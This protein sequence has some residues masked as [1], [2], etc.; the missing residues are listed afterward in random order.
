MLGERC[1]C[2]GIDLVLWREEKTQ[3]QPDIRQLSFFYLCSPVFSCHPAV[4]AASCQ[5]AFSVT[6][7]ITTKHK[8]VEQMYKLIRSSDWNAASEQQLSSSRQLCNYTVCLFDCFSVIIAAG[9]KMMLDCLRTNWLNNTTHAW[10]D[11]WIPFF[12]F[13]GKDFP[14]EEGSR[15]LWR[16]SWTGEAFIIDLSLGP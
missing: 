15:R 9:M 13:Q 2:W 12:V 6:A 7:H 3:F 14:W 16:Q 11:S 10:N 5:I 1:R 4:L 8:R